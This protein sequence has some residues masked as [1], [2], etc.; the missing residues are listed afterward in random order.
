MTPLPAPADS[1][2]E[3]RDAI[4][5]RMEAMYFNALPVVNLDGGENKSPTPLDE[6][7]EYHLPAVLKLIQASNTALLEKL[8]KQLDVN[9]VHF[10]D[11]AAALLAVDALLE[12]ERDKSDV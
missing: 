3:L 12:A 9:L 7:L 4:K 11:H 1:E 5:A 10:N 2:G 6:A 8:R